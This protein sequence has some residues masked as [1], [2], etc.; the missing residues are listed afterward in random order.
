M[1]N[2]ADMDVIERYKQFRDCMIRV[3][4]PVGGGIGYGNCQT[5]I[6]GAWPEFGL[7]GEE[8]IL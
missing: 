3:Q 1:V 7:T 4:D 5:H 6:H 2:S 8:P